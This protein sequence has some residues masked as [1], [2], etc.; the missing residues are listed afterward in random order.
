MGTPGGNHLSRFFSIFVLVSWQVHC[1]PPPP[2]DP[3]SSGPKPPLPDG[4]GG[5]ALLVFKWSERGRSANFVIRTV[6]DCH[7]LRT[8][9]YYNNGTEGK[10]GDDAAIRIMAWCGTVVLYLP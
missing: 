7:F 4:H 5:R 9:C 8:E 10:M 2:F 6:H 3:Y 1:P